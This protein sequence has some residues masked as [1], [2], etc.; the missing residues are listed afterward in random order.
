MNVDDVGLVGLEGVADEE[1]D[2]FGGGEFTAPF[3][4]VF[5]TVFGLASAGAVKEADFVSARLEFV[6]GDDGVGFRATERAEA[7]VYKQNPHPDWFLYGDDCGERLGGG[8]STGEI[9]V[10][11]WNYSSRIRERHKSV[12]GWGLIVSAAGCAE[13]GWTLKFLAW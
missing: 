13:G 8:Q 7:F 11:Y 12:R 3:K 1:G 2:V 10:R 6:G 4:D 5:P 9:K